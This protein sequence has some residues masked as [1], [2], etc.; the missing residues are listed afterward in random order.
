MTI[1]EMS[2]KDFEAVPHHGSFSPIEPIPFDSLVIIPGNSRPLHSSGYRMMSFVA[3]KNDTPI[4]RLSGYS[5]VI[6]LDGVGGFG[7]NWL[8]KLNP[9]YLP[10]PNDLPTFKIPTSVS[11]RAW[12]IDY[13]PKSGL[14]RLFCF[15]Y[16]LVA[17]TWTTSSFFLYT[18]P[19]PVP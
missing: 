12:T 4:L 6:L 3:V 14:M 19:I 1:Y 8:P 18:E 7:R 13:L 10:S 16:N 2:R 5:D 15:G 11:P 9:G 17:D